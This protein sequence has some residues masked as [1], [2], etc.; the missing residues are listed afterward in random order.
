M[1]FYGRS[2]VDSNMRDHMFL[3]FMLLLGISLS[4]MFIDKK[5]EAVQ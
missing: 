5:D 1:G 2:I 4:C 3:Q